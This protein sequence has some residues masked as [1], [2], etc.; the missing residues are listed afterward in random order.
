MLCWDGALPCAALVDSIPI[1]WGHE[2]SK[3]YIGEQRQNRYLPLAFQDFKMSRRCIISIICEFK[4]FIPIAKYDEPLYPVQTYAL[5]STV[6]PLA[7]KSEN[8][9]SPFCS[10][11]LTHIH[12]RS[13]IYGGLSTY[14]VTLALQRLTPTLD[15]FLHRS[16]HILFPYFVID[17]S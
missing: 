1:S 15:V 9:N 3:A 7:K 11:P 6:C 13:G 16:F 2:K 4:S 14:D 5:R 10:G 12:A 17:L 8:L